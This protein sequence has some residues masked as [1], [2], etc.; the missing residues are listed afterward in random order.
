MKK[1]LLLAYL[2]MTTINLSASLHDTEK[3]PPSSPGSQSMSEPE[4]PNPAHW[5]MDNVPGSPTT[6][7]R[8]KS[9]QSWPQ[10]PNMPAA[11]DNDPEYLPTR[12]KKGDIST[13]ML[14]KLDEN[15]LCL[16]YNDDSGIIIILKQNEHINLMDIADSLNNSDSTDLTCKKDSNNCF[17]TFF[18]EDT[19]IAQIICLGESEKLLPKLYTKISQ[20]NRFCIPIIA[21]TSLPAIIAATIGVAVG[22]HKIAQ[23]PRD[24]I[25]KIKE[26]LNQRERDIIAQATL[27]KLEETQAQND[28]ILDILTKIQ[29]KEAP[30][31]PTAFKPKN[32]D[33]P[34][35]ETL[36]TEA[37]GDL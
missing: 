13:P 10:T 27:N 31:R 29:S 9:L 12:H 33:L 6:I 8:V 36:N 19:M 34:S 7:K 24:M 16:I 28:R 11:M 20:P 25:K 37:T 3:T 15:G 14:H 4:T 35:L 1:I 23:Q 22:A 21:A 2:V 30:Q 26:R 5:A 17:F 32:S 18:K